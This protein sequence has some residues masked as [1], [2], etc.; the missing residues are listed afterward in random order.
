[1][2]SAVVFGKGRV[3][4]HALNKLIEL[5]Y[6][7]SYVVPTEPQP[8]IGVN[9]VQE[10]ERHGCKVQKIRTLD[11]LPEVEVDL[12]LSVY[13]N[14]IF[15]QRHIDRFGTLLNV[16]NAPLPRNR[17]VLPVNWALRNHEVTH[18]VTLHVI[19]EGIDV[20][21]VVSQR[22]FPMDHRTDEVEDVYARCLDNAEIMLSEALPKL[23]E[24]PRVAQDHGLATYHHMNEAAQLGNRK[25]WRRNHTELLEPTREL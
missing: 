20:G 6:E 11:D 8:K 3:A 21:P 23:N 9:F 17:G 19:E 12:G 5:G 22:I 14:R 1:M 4:A 13:Y 16:H 2:P 25:F 15:K 7:I 24:L 10:A 18:G